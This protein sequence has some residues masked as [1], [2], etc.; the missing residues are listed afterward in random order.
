MKRFLLLCAAVVAMTGAKAQTTYNWFDAADCDANGWLWFDTQAKIDKYCGYTSDY[1][2]QMQSATFEN[3]DGQYEDTYADP[4]VAGYDEAGNTGT[5]DCYDGAIV[6]AAGTKSIG[7]TEPDGG[8]ILMWLPDCAQVD[9][10]LSTA[11]AHIC[12]GLKAIMGSWGERVD[13]APVKGYMKMGL[14]SKPLFSGHQYEWKNIQE[15]ANE[16]APY[17]TW[18][19]EQGK[20]VTCYLGNS[21]ND[22]ILIHGIR[23]KTYTAPAGVG[24][25]ADGDNALGLHCSGKT[26]LASENANIKV[27]AADGALAAEGEGTE[28]QLNSLGAGVYVARATSAAGNATVKVI[29]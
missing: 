24:S 15:L 2:I 27:Y 1:K 3:A 28:L 29:L 7:N 22:P 14:F 4:D 25:I 5:D 18:K 20:K 9:M 10:M 21:I 11:H 17:T 23:V 12:V 8:G 6:L 19:S 13:C 16:N 26:I